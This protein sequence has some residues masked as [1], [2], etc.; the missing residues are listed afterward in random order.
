MDRT[1][2][3]CGRAV[4][5]RHSPI[6]PQARNHDGVWRRDVQLPRASSIA[7]D[8]RPA[9]GGNRRA[10]HRRGL[11]SGQCAHN[12]MEDPSVPGSLAG[13]SR[14][15]IGHWLRSPGLAGHFRAD[16]FCADPRLAPGNGPCDS[17]SFRDR[18]HGDIPSLAG[19]R[20]RGRCELGG[21]QLRCPPDCCLRRIGNVFVRRR[22]E[23]HYPRRCRVAPAL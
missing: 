2:Q 14:D 9:A 22:G 20:I 5:R 3:T 16:S 1:Y 7:A 6:H 23:H 8:L 15:W 21:G 19:Y 11:G 18:A 17:L 12:Q 4:R 13:S 10:H